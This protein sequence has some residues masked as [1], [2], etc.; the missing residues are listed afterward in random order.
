MKRVASLVL[1]LTLA[2]AP[3][4]SACLWDNDTLKEESLGQGDVA[5]IVK[6]KI[7][8]HS[9]FFYEEKVKYTKA[10][11]DKGDAPAERYDDLAVA[12]DKLGLQKEAIAVMEAKEARFPGLYTTY[13]NLGTF[14][15]HAGE[16]EKG[17]ELLKKAVTINPEAHFGR[18]EYQIKAIEYLLAAKADPKLVQKKDFLGLDVTDADNLLRFGDTRKAFEKAGLKENVFVAL[19]GIIRFGNGEQ[20]PHVWF[21]LGMAL[22][23]KGDRQ[24]AIRA[25]RRAELLGH[26]IAARAAEIMLDHIRKLE[27]KSW[28]KVAAELDREF[29]KG[30]TASEAQQKK[31]DDLIR[32]GKQKKVFGY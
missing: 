3:Q 12:Y 21:S 16:L 29:A 27:G 19:A 30:Q 13:A 18:E 15:A 4:A 22:G 1:V 2:Q 6:G 28:K 23:Y 8:K 31:E 11:V 17:L 14:Y 26:P 32:A 24:L 5:E 7:P 9:S 10:L 20:S 25:F